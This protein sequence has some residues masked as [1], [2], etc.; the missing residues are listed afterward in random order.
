M[1]VII[2]VGNEKGGTGKTTTA[3]NLAA[4]AAGRGID[5]V[6]VDGDTQGSSLSWSA[7]RKEYEVEPNVPVIAIH[8]KTMAKELQDLKKRYQLIIVDVGGRDSVELRGAMVVADHLISPTQASQF[9]LWAF[10]RLANTVNE[11]SAI[12]P[13]LQV[14]VVLTRAS[15][16]PKI[17]ESQEARDFLGDLEGLHVSEVVIRDRIAYRK[18]AIAGMSVTEY[19]VDAKA[20]AEMNDLFDKTIQPYFA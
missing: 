20:S 16:N 10:S 12:N 6:L 4:I 17:S 2:A 5:V 14:S 18:A 1:S 15:T 9:D 19:G 7:M 11:C 8:G 3:T 13:N